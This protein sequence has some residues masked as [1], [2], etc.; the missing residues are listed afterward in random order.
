MTEKIDW[1]KEVLE[2]EPNSKVFFPLAKL[3]VKDGLNAEAISTLEK[4]LERHP[5]FLEAR[6][7]LIELLHRSGQTGE[8]NVQIAKLSQIFASYAGFW[9]AWAAC[10][11]SVPEDADTAAIVRVL[12]AT[13][14][15]GPLQLHQVLEKGAAAIIQEK[16]GTEQ[17]IQPAAATSG[18]I[19]PEPLQAVTQADA[20]S[21]K[22]ANMTEEGMLVQSASQP[23]SEMEPE[24][25]AD[26]QDEVAELITTPAEVPP[27]ETT[28]AA[29]DIS[30]AETAENIAL[31]DASEDDSQLIE[32]PA[33]I[34]AMPEEESIEAAAL[35]ED[36]PALEQKEQEG[37][38]ESLSSIASD[39]SPELPAKA[40]DVEVLK[41]EQAEFSA[42]AKAAEEIAPD[43]A[44][45][46][47]SLRTR[48]MADV[49]ADQGDIEGA[50]DIYAELAASASG[51]ELAELKQRMAE[52]QA[53]QETQEEKN[54]PEP[55]APGSENILGILEAL[56]RRVEARVNN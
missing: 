5:E 51:D 13:F 41:P 28:A 7:L 35:P 33:P 17:A 21:E 19:Q 46:P 37:V 39:D 43:E 9:Q 29:N 52:L 54:S 20:G 8:C 10:L 40:A 47:F 53:R 2:I 1:Y 26:A 25:S 18:R 48:S 49:L 36:S 42:T 34:E 55:I 27:A 50:L 4:G 16:T 11:A 44:E 45:E 24:L 6:L 22:M 38:E 3:L 14:I 31:P 32:S 56:A 23:V 30:E 15:A 12:A